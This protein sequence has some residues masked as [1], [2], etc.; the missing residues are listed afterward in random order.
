M[1]ELFD[2]E[3]C[4]DYGRAGLR[5]AREDIRCGKST[6]RESVYADLFIIA[7]DPPKKA[8]KWPFK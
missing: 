2:K 5:V 4:V 6:G 3:G 8:N 1:E 7:A